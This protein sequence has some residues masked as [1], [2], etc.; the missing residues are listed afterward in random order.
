MIKIL[1]KPILKEKNMTMTELHKATNIS[2]KTL[3]LIANQKTESIQFHTIERLSEVLNV[4]INELFT[5][6]DD[7]YDISVNLIAKNEAIIKLI[8][9]ESNRK[10]TL[11]IKFVIDSMELDRY[12]VLGIRVNLIDIEDWRAIMINILSRD[13]TV[14]NLIKILGYTI[15]EA[16]ISKYYSEKMDFYDDV[17]FTWKGAGILPVLYTEMVNNVLLDNLNEK[18]AYSP[19]TYVI[20]FVPRYPYTPMK[21]EEQNNSMKKSV[22]FEDLICLRNLYAIE[23]DEEN[24]WERKISICLT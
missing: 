6:V 12:N 8:H 24:D 15:T 9:R 22:Q 14:E 16:I 20:N 2:M 3:S 10:Y 4:E 13:L 7:V 18:I 1:L 21:P 5:I 23:Y 19:Q 17:Y 11:D